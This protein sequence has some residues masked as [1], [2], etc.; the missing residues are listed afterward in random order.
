MVTRVLSVLTPLP[1]DSELTGH[2]PPCPSSAFVNPR[3]GVCGRDVPAAPHVPHTPVPS[4]AQPRPPGPTTG[5]GAGRLEGWS[6]QLDSHRE[7][8]TDGQKRRVVSPPPGAVSPLTEPRWTPQTLGSPLPNVVGQPGREA[9]SPP[10]H[11]GYTLSSCPCRETGPPLGSQGLAGAG[12]FCLFFIDLLYFW[13]SIRFTGKQQ[14]GKR[15]H[16]LVPIQCP[17]FL[18]PCTCHTREPKGDPLTTA[19]RIPQA[20]SGSVSGSSGLGFAT[21]TT[22]LTQHVTNSC[23]NCPRS[24]RRPFPRAGAGLCERG[25]GAGV[26]EQVYPGVVPTGTRLRACGQHLPPGFLGRRHRVCLLPLLPGSQGAGK[27]GGEEP[28]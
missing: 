15:V 21:H 19:D 17:W 10:L 8:W 6:S 9:Q 26:Q 16:I 3:W 22:S 12:S 27:A 11:G 1:A 14:G 13:R 25:T 20:T 7:G 18:A 28:A 4:P 5:W 23:S 24:E 2:L